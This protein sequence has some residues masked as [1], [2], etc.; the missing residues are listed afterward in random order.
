MLAPLVD[1][2]EC[3]C[4]PLSTGESE[5][6]IIWIGPGTS[7][8]RL[9][10]PMS[11]VSFEIVWISGYMHAVSLGHQDGKK[12]SQ[13]KEEGKPVEAVRYSEQYSAGKP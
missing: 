6:T 2:F 10:G 5:H 7:E 11:P 3:P 12:A 9:L 13:Q 4:L 1:R 8:T